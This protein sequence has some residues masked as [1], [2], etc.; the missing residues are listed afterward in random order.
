MRHRFVSPFGIFML[1]LASC[2]FLGCGSNTET[3]VMEEPEE[4]TQEQEEY[5]EQQMEEMNNPEYR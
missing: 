1:G 4:L 2:L 3:E 5:Y